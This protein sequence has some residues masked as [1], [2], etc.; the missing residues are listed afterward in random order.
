MALILIISALVLLYYSGCLSS[1]NL[2]K[3]NKSPYKE[4]ISKPLSLN[5][6]YV[7]CEN[8]N[9]KD[10]EF[11]YAI[12]INEYIP[13]DWFVIDTL[14]KG[15]EIKLTKA[16]QFRTKLSGVIGSYVIGTV[17]ADSL[18]KEICFAYN[19]GTQENDFSTKKRKIYWS[20]PRAIWQEKEDTTKYYTK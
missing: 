19:W 10:P 5:D 11:R 15:T 8:R 3:S 13:A 2:D 17:Y 6:D 9:P 14:S 7:L 20:F 1:E 4:Y 18:K 16:M 12:L